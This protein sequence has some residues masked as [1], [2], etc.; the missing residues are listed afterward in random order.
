MADFT[1][2]YNQD[3]AVRLLKN[4]LKSHKISHAYMIIGEAG[5]GKSAIADAFAKNLLCESETGEACNNCRSCHQ[6]DSHNHPDIIYVI[7]EKDGYISVEDIRDKVNSTIT[8]RPYQ[9]K[10]KVYIIPHAEWMG[11]GAENALLKTMEEPPEYAVIVLLTDNEEHFLP[12]ILSRVVNIPLVP[13][14]YEKKIEEESFIELKN[15]L[16]PYFAANFD[17]ELNAVEPIITEIAKDKLV[18]LKA[19]EILLLF[20]R[21]VLIYKSTNDESLVLLKSELF[22]IKKKADRIEYEGINNIIKEIEIS[23]RRIE[24]SVKEE[25]VL[26]DLFMTIKENDK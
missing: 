11:E 4:A 13:I 24:M 7:P 2:V 1:E 16:K 8:I 14:S 15:R 22:D 26:D 10:Y 19:M 5:T 18:S 20:Y 12:T 3:M 17:T 9:G 21:D 23:R 25:Y 6:A